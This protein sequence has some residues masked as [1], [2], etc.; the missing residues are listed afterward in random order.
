MKLAV[1]KSTT[2]NKK[3]SFNC[4][5]GNFRGTFLELKPVDGCD[6]NQPEVRLLFEMTIPS[7]PEAKILTRKDFSPDLASGSKLRRFL[8]QW[9]G[10]ELFKDVE[11]IEFDDL[12]GFE[13]DLTIVHYHNEGHANPYCDIRAAYPAGT[14]TLTEQPIQP[15]KPQQQQTRTSSSSL[16][17][18]VSIAPFAA[19]FGNPVPFAQMVEQA[20]RRERARQQESDAK[21]K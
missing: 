16:C 14:L 15:P 13:A 18:S 17:R 20:A 11:E 10:S 4:P 7:M 3:T 9:L 12:A 2:R 19:P 8:E 21:T 1:P 5:E 6:A